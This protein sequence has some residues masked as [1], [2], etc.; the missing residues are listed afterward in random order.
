[1]KNIFYYIKVDIIYITVVWGPVLQICSDLSL[2]A[3]GEQ[4]RDLDD[5]LWKV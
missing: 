3:L 2:G 1:M 4:C 5:T